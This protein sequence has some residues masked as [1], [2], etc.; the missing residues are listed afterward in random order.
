MSLDWLHIPNY[1]G[2][3]LRNFEIDFDEDQST[4]VLIGR[5]GSG[6]SNLIE[7]IV[8]IFRDLELGNPPPFAYQLRYVCRDQVIELNADP[9]RGNKKLEVT[10]D[11]KTITQTA[12]QRDLANY[13]PNFVFAYY[14]GWSSRLEKHFDEPTRRYYREILNSKKSEMPLRRMFFCRKEYSQ[15]VLLAFFLSES[16]TAHQLLKHYLGIRRFDSALFVLKTPWWRGSGKPN[17]TQLSEG[18]SRFWY[19]RGAFKTFLDRLWSHAF[20]PIRNTESVERDVRG[21]TENTERLYLFIKN[22][23]E[24]AQLK[25]G[26]EDAKTLFGYLESLFLCDLMDEVRVTVERT[27]GTRVKFAQLSEGEQQ[28][29]TVLGLMLFTQ[30]DESLYLLDEPDTHLNP[31]WTYDYLKLLQDNIRAEKGQLLVATHNPLMIGSLYK[32]Q[33]RIITQQEQAT[34]VEE[35]EYDPIGIGVEGL[36]KSE[37]YGL[38]STLAPEILEKLD[39]HYEL[40]GKRDKTSEEELTLIKLANELNSLHVSRTHPN[41]Y[42]E[43][44][45]NAMAKK[46]PTQETVLTKAEIDAQTQLADEVLAE[47]LADENALKESARQ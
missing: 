38:R 45:A 32:N 39:R 1:R 20:A 31:V 5:N 2:R 25:T 26:Q 46:L 33:V 6:K 10:V 24:L 27:D 12:F 36:L 37:L 4:T 18:D 28:L 35:P 34:L 8:E 13:L 43:Q 40:L 21:K 23:T 7:A 30:N 11:G 9:D 47:I 22:Q 44:F 14:S 19:A 17:K 3:N 15:L 42:F 16:A 41:P 29:L